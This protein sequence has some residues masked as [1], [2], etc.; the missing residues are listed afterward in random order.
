MK[1]N[2]LHSPDGNATSTRRPYNGEL[3]VENDDFRLEAERL[4]VG[5][6]EVVFHLKGGDSEGAYSVEGRSTRT[7]DGRYVSA[8]LPVRYTQYAV[9]DQAVIVLQV[10]ETQRGCRVSGEW[11]QDGESYGFHGLLVPFR[12]Q[13]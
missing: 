11:L 9:E 6:G 4:I 13:T 7:S 8:R 12:A 1:F 10:E 3:S 2:S 5:D